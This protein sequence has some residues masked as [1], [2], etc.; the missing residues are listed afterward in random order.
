MRIASL[1]TIFSCIV[2]AADLAPTHR[3]LEE[4]AAL[5]DEAATRI[6]GQL[7]KKPDQLHKRLQML[8]YYATKV[9]A[10]DR[11]SIK[12][13][14]ARHILWLVEMQP[15]ADIFSIAS[16]VFAIY[17]TGDAL[18]DP[19][20]FARGR[21]LWLRHIEAAPKDQELKK[22]AAIWIEMG[23]PEL[24]ERLLRDALELRW[25]GQIYARALLGAG[26][27][28]YRTGEAA[29][30]DPG[31]RDSAFA[32]H[33]KKE[34]ANSQDA[35]LLGG[36]GW[37]LARVGGKLYAAGKLD[38]DYSPTARELL[39]RAAALDPSNTDVF[40]ADPSLPARG[41]QPPQILRIGGNVMRQNLRRKITPDYPED[42][43]HIKG[44]VRIQA[45]IGADGKM[46]K[47]RVVSGPP[48]LQ[49]VSVAAVKQWEYK[50]TLLNGK[51]V[52]VITLIDIAFQ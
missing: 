50:P 20:A 12:A 11:E 21:A 6:E 36:A 42:A 27:G 4:G 8:A 19:A 51:P 2:L 43:R 37:T 24:T 47:L 40:M 48:E 38:W 49:A 14:R 3:A 7:E 17:P 5:S 1:A 32:A 29:G 30:I 39:E 16:R 22:N 31:L 33:A 13:A 26:W 9:S 15:K 28:D 45:M 18:A 52:R 34:L 10:P 35:S 23:D 44:T 25:L 46:E 41:S